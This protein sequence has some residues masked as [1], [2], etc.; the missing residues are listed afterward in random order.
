MT[1]VSTVSRHELAAALGWLVDA[2]V[3]TI[4]G[5]TPFAWLAPV[6]P[7]AAAASETIAVE[8]VA[9]RAE[10][11]A[12]NADSLAALAAALVEAYPTSLFAEGTPGGAMV[13]G[14]R[15][16]VADAKA[17]KV[18]GDL[19]GVLLDRMLAS[20]GLTRETAYLANTV[21]WP[22]AAD[23]GPTAAEIAAAAP[24]LR[25]QIVLAR[26]RAILALG[27]TAATALTGSR[28]GI[29]RLRG[30][31]HEVDIDGVPVAVMPSFHPAQ[32][33]LHPGHK[34]AAWADLRAFRE[35]IPA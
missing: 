2:G 13:I 1:E 3:D 17:G 34:A 21:A 8:Q 4:V 30:R 23:R 25:R 31:W 15:P 20:I 14:E 32:L 10:G 16:T 19:A 28:D 35:R 22:L 29:N 5:D 27:Q 11:S 24:Y 7:V 26:P 18:F 33:L 6:G 9:A 12:I